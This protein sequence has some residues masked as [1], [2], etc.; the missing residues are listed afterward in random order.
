VK[1]TILIDVS[2]VDEDS[3]DRNALRE[4][5]HPVLVCHG[6]PPKTLCPILRGTTCS[7]IDAAHG[8]IFELDL[9]RSQHRAILERYKQVVSSEVPIRVV[10]KP[11][12]ER[13]YPEAVAGVEVW[14]R[15]PTSDDLSA[16]SADVDTSPADSTAS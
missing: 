13:M 6:P 8:V 16:F 12:Q 14:P 10:V 2:T 11:G 7:L 9:E 15:R 1:G 3:I 5:G 4:L